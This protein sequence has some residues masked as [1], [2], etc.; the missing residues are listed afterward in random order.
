MGR[1][2]VT[3]TA[4]LLA[5]GS[6]TASRADNAL[7]FYLGIAAG[8]ANIRINGA[9][10]S[11]LLYGDFHQNDVGWKA[12]AGIRPISLIGAEVQYV[13]FGNAS[14]LSGNE[15][16]QQAAAAYGMLYLPIPVPLFDVYAKAGLAWLR[17]AAHTQMYGTAPI[18]QYLPCGTSPYT[19]SRND[20]DAAFG[21][22][23]QFKFSR[24]A[25]RAEYE[26]VQGSA[27]KPDLASIGLTWTL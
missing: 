18:C 5:L 23:V 26:R 4:S 3:M 21:A 12:F 7:N 15:V 25:I 2:L 8:T 22:G 24:L 6:S 13:D 11:T 19:F 17:S 14:D 1:F 9:N 20:A 16:H 27:A 10:N